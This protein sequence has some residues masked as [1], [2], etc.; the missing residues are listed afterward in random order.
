MT[1][2]LTRVKIALGLM[3][4]GQGVEKP[5]EQKIQCAVEGVLLDGTKIGADAFEAGNP[6]YVIAEDGSTTPAPEGIHETEDLKITVDAN[7]II[8]SVEPKAEVEAPEAEVAMEDAGTGVPAETPVADSETEFQKTVMTLLEAVATK[9]A[10]LETRCASIESKIG[11]T[12]QK[13][14]KFAKA[15]GAEKVKNNPSLRAIGQSEASTF[16]KKLDIL[17]EIKKSQ[18]K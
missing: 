3:E 9:C 8:A 5:A 15:P 13:M 14:E 11:Q 10:A 7:G 18:N 4:D 2:V 12:E 1:D 17:K 6:L 16:D